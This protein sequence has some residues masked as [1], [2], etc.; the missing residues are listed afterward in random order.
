MLSPKQ[1]AFDL[2]NKSQNILIVLPKN[3]SADN[4]GSALALFILLNGLNKKAEIIAQEPIAERLSFFPGLEQIKEEP[5]ALRD[6][7]ISI[8]TSQ[9]SIKRLRYET[10]DSLLKIFLSSPDKLEEKDVRLEPG[11]YNYDA[12]IIIGAQDMES[13]GE[14]YEKHTELFFQKPIL[15]IDYRSG[16][17]LF[18]EINLVEITASSAAEIL[19]E[20]ILAFFPNSISQPIA[21]CLLAG[22]IDETHSFQNTNAT[23]QTFNLASSLVTHGAEKE[24]IIQA[25]YKTKPLNYL[26]LWGRLLG[27]LNYEPDKNLAWL[28]ASPEDFQETETS[29]SDLYTISDEVR[30][31]LPQLNAA[32]IL[33]PEEQEMISAIIQSSKID[34]L[35]KINLELGGA[36]KNNLILAKAIGPDLLSAKA[37]LE[38]LINS[39]L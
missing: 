19:T 29:S 15:N 35:Q 24:K 1:Q 34:L 33:W 18:G 8:D 12:I 16:N 2:L 14:F 9:K 17:E 26:R 28:E 31:L 21:T 10:K 4:L 25:L 39:F 32:I 20:F 23:P 27:R 11:P 38:N 6:F 30:S 22:I 7:I 3:Q 37:R 36:L 13:L 5:A